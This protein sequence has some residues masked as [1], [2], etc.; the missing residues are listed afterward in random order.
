MTFLK[1]KKYIFFW[2]PW[3]GKRAIM[4][5]PTFFFF[6]EGVR[7]MKEMT[8]CACI[9]KVRLH[10]IHTSWESI[11][12][13]HF[14]PPILTSGGGGASPA[15]PLLHFLPLMNGS[16]SRPLHPPS[17]PCCVKEKGKDKR[18]EKGERERKKE[19]EEEICLFA[20]DQR[21]SAHQEK[22]LAKPTLVRRK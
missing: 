7:D 1:C 15:S 12:R 6:G 19:G 4:P 16:L 20:S 13:S 10:V 9:V 17:F 8:H 11:T 21:I 18:G 5:I 2:R 14:F 3:D 22:F